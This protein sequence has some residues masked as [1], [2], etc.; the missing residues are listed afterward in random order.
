[1]MQVTKETEHMV[2]WLVD[3]IFENPNELIYAL[4]VYASKSD[5]KIDVY[6]IWVKP[7]ALNKVIK[8]YEEEVEHV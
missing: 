6:N 7:K 2:V 3:T 8:L 1:M 4:E 5:Y